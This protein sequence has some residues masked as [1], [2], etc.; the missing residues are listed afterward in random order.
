[1]AVSEPRSRAAWGASAGS[2]H[3]AHG[4]PGLQRRDDLV[5]PGLFGDG[6]AV[7]ATGVFGDAL[8][9]PFG[10]LE[11]GERELELDVSTSRSGC[12]SPSGCMTPA[13][14]WARTTCTSASVSRMLARKRLPRPSPCVR[15]GDEPSDVVEVDGVVDDL[16]RA[17]RGGDLVQT[18]VHDGHHGDVGLDRGERVVGGLHP[19]AE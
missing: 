6:D 3:G 18:P 11:V 13:S 16:R 1:M 2:G 17:H 14:R 4:P 15:A 12:T 10:L 7:S 9:A 8:Y 19:R 5:Q